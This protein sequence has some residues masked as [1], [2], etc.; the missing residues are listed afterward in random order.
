[1]ANLDAFDVEVDLLIQITELVNAILEV[2]F[3]Y[4]H[5]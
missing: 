3:A 2:Q 4:A 5:I 1:V